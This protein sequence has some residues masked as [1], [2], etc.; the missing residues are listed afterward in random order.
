M[1]NLESHISNIYGMQGK[2]WLEN[3]PQK[4]NNIAAKLGLSELV[5]ISNLSYNYVLSGFQ[6]SR[7]II[8]KLGFDN[9]DMWQEVSALRAFPSSSVSE[10]IHADREF[11]LLQRILPG[12]SLKSLSQEGKDNEA[13]LHFCQLVKKLHSDKIP[14]Q[15]FSS[16]A[17]KWGSGFD[18][19]LSS[20]DCQIEKSL[21]EDA[22][23]LF[24][25]LCQSQSKVILLHG[26]LHHDNI[27]YDNIRRWVAIDPK[28]IIGEA[29]IEV[30]AFLKNPVG[31]QEI[32]G[33]MEIIYTRVNIISECLN[34]N[35]QRI[36]SW[37]YVLTI[38][39]CIWLT[40]INEN[41]DNWLKLAKTLKN[42]I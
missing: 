1:N 39:S 6:G 24:F 29:E 20:K 7:P 32:Y 38:L 13:S 41:P 37:V 23:Q 33:N 4:I 22:K 42:I 40:Q 8:L 2:D 21:V 3:L 18:E 26:D 14:L 31:H 16:V 5:P 25:S 19:Y 36:L 12:I 15:G 10:V 9:D 34:L 27:L 17:E 28:G 35:R 11:I 30:S